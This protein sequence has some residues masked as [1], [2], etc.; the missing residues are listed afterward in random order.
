MD[1]IRAVSRIKGGWRAGRMTH[2]RRL[3]GDSTDGFLGKSEVV[4]KLPRWLLNFQPLA[5]RRPGRRAAG[6]AP[7]DNF[8]SR[9][10]TRALTKTA[11]DIDCGKSHVFASALRPYGRFQCMNSQ[12]RRA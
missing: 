12:L 6:S 5:G 3:G 10:S 2:V 9:R 1:S 4:R 7:R 11:Q 8:R